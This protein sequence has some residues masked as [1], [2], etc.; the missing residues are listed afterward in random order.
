MVSWTLRPAAD[1][2]AHLVLDH[3]G[4]LAS[5]GMPFEGL[6]D[7]WRGKLAERTAAV[8]GG[9]SGSDPIGAKV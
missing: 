6:G 9:A 1:G 5:Q 4:F 2:G 8:V 3:S 7:G